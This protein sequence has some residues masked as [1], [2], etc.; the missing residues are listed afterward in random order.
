[1]RTMLGIS[2]AFAVALEAPVARAETVRSFDGVPIAY[3][4]AGRGGTS[5]VF[6]HG[7]SCDRTYWA[8]QME[9]LATSYRVVSIDLAGHGDSGANRSAWSM[10]AFGQDIAAVLDHLALKNVIMVG[11]SAAGYS[12]LEAGKIRP[13]R[14][15]ALIGVDAYRNISTGYFD[16]RYSEDELKEFARPLQQDFVGN[17]EAL[18]RKQFFLPESDPELVDRV[19]RDMAAAPPQVAIPSMLAYYRYRNDHLRDALREV[20]PRLPIIAINAEKSKID[21]SVFRTYVARFEV[22][23]L[24]GAGHFLMLE[25]PRELNGWLRLAVAELERGLTTR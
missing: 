25:R 24:P 11:H 3:T 7:W 1:M 2:L 6:V 14:V 23:Y 8:A 13:K 4:V 20:G 5:L 18:V 19:A 12:I 16:R 10:E 21:P 15:V 22:S 17:M 9:D